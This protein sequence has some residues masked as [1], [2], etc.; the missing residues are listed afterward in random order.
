MF[1]LQRLP[2][3]KEALHFRIGGKNIAEVSAMSIAEFADWMEHIEEH[4]SDKERKI[5]QE[6]LKEIRER[7]RFLMDV[8][9]GYLSFRQGFAIA[10]G[11]RKPTH[12]AGHAD[13]LEAGQCPIYIG[14][15]LHRT[16]P[17]RQP[18]TDTQSGRVAR[19][20]KLGHCRLNTTKI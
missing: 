18:E 4:L 1:G 17:T 13:R 3:E 7:L 8:G 12:P 20:G 2:T 11:R 6:I 19:C 5:A 16:A 9:L 14:R 15:T 10:V